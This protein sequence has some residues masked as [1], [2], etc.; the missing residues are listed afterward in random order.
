LNE[1]R[2]DEVKE[3]NGKKE[4]YDFNKEK[5]K[6]ESKIPDKRPPKHY[7]I[8]TYDI[9]MDKLKRSKRV[10]NYEQKILKCF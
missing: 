9:Y 5:I 6:Y 1:V 10:L 3:N 7:A 4:N 8:T 2:E